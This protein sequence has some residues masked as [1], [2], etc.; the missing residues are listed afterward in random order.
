MDQT[1]HTVAAIT[2]VSPTNDDS[3][4]TPSLM[5]EYSFTS[6]IHQCVY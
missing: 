4:G 6:D 5:H 2:N 3:V 1:N